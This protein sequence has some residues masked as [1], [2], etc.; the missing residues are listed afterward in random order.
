MSALPLKA[1]I[2]RGL[3]GPEIETGFYSSGE[4]LTFDSTALIRR[5]TSI[6]AERSKFLDDSPLVYRYP[7]RTF[8]MSPV[9][10]ALAS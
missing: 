8:G 9:R 3:T 5:F 7:D 1:D 2:R 4:L 6:R 10:I